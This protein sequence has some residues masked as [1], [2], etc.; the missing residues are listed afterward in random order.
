[1]KVLVAGSSARAVAESVSQAGHETFAVDMFGDRDLFE[2]A[3]WRR[4]DSDESIAAAAREFEVDGVTFASGVENTPDLV[5][6]LRTGGVK[7][8]APECETLR[9]CRYNDVLARI[10]CYHDIA[11]PA[12][13]SSPPPPGRRLLVKPFKSGAGI[14]VR[15]WNGDLSSIEPGEYFQEKVEGIPIS[16]IFVAD[17]K[18]AVVLGVSR[19]FAGEA[20]LGASGYA[21]CGNL[22]PLDIIPEERGPLL[23]ELR[24]I[25][26]A[27]TADFGLIGACGADFILCGKTP[28]LLE[29][30]PRICASFEL[31]EELRCVN[32]FELHVSALE[33]RLPEDPEGLLDGPFIGKGIVYAPSDMTAPDTGAW[34][35][36]DRHDIPQ[37]FS[38]LPA[39]QP[40]CTV[41]TPSMKGEEDVLTYLRAAA[42]AVWKECI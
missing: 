4:L 12:V 34:L 33:G 32:I 29:I 14:G 17:G 20:F 28:W 2:V 8:F 31:A 41:I 9:R 15:D 25:A 16:A 40:I 7:V 35:G 30:N 22:M 10:C 13:F 21:W 42:R 37:A 39:G 5:G 6:L 1:M 27:L 11:R 38:P 23:A 26:S 24:R 19:Q 3:L 36:T 18:R